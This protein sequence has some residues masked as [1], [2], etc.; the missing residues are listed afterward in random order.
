MCS[1]SNV[2]GEEINS[3]SYSKNLVGLGATRTK[4]AY[5]RS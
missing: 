1:Y 5:V 3:S 4:W 2:A